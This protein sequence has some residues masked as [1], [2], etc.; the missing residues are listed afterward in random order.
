MKEDD[1]VGF[2]LLRDGNSRNESG[3][4]DQ[5]LRSYGLG[6]PGVC[7]GVISRLCLGEDS[8]QSPS[9]SVYLS[10]LLLLNTV[11]VES[12]QLLRDFDPENQVV[13][14]Q[15]SVSPGPGSVCSPASVLVPHE[16]AR[17]NR[18]QRNC[19]FLLRLSPDLL[20]CSSQGSKGPPYTQL[21]NEKSG[22]IL[23]TSRAPSV[24]PPSPSPLHPFSSF[25]PRPSS[26]S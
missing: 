4:N 21:P 22:S 15:P 10:S 9:Y 17:F 14:L 19:P 5:L 2:F 18:F 26:Q 13:D 8:G 1:A 6:E 7:I 11:R 16:H 20:L 23:D 12:K 3:V 25:P 24:S